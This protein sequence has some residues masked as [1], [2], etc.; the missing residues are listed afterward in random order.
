MWGDAGRIAV[1]VFIWALLAFWM[2]VWLRVLLQTLRVPLASAIA[3]ALS[4]IGVG[5]SMPSLLRLLASW[6]P[7]WLPVASRCST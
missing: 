5:L 1:D 7:A 6:G 2:W 3:A 4:W